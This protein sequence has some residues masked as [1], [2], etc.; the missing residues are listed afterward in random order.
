MQ[1]LGV[2]L[3]R[4]V[5]QHFYPSIIAFK[6]H[7]KLLFYS[8]PNVVVASLRPRPYLPDS[9][10]PFVYIYIYSERIDS[11]VLRQKLTDLLFECHEKCNVFNKLVKCFIFTIGLY[12]IPAKSLRSFFFPILNICVRLSFF[13]HPTQPQDTQFI[14]KLLKNSR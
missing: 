11:W 4:L 9:K 12:I 10:L 8:F 5:C 6:P 1:T 3:H 14:N 13:Y 2:H 7:A